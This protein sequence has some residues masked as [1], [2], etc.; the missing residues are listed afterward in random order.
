M[1]SWHVPLSKAA[2]VAAVTGVYD[3]DLFA[4]DDIDVAAAAPA[5]VQGQSTGSPR[6]GSL[7]VSFTASDSGAEGSTTPVVAHKM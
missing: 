6:N 4:P 5:H 7:S 2:A 3:D 1:Q